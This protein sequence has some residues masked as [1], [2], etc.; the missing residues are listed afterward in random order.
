MLFIS[1]CPL[2]P[3][4]EAFAQWAFFTSCALGMSYLSV[5]CYDLPLVNTRCPLTFTYTQSS[6]LTA[7]FTYRTTCSRLLVFRWF[8]PCSLLS[9]PKL[10]VCRHYCWD[11]NS[12]KMMSLVPSSHVG[13]GE[14]PTIP[15][16]SIAVIFLLRYFICTLEIIFLKKYDSLSSYPFVINP[17]RR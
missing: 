4:M 8:R 6:L 7:Q 12:V 2:V 13:H 5:I 1:L 15:N 10:C 14:F 3:L 11:F 9:Y 16:S 17:K